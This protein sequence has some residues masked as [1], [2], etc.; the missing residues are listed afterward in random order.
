MMANQMNPKRHRSVNSKVASF[1]RFCNASG[2]SA[3]VIWFDYTGH[4]VLYTLLKPGQYIDMNTFVSHPWTFEKSSTGDRLNANFSQTFYPEDKKNCRQVVNITYPMYSLKE[5]S[6]QVIRD[7]IDVCNE[8]D[9]AQLELPKPLDGELQFLQ[10][11][12]NCA[13]VHSREPAG[14]E[15][16]GN[17]VVPHLCSFRNTL[18]SQF[19]QFGRY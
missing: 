10:T 15:N 5:R 3:S 16:A 19:S 2:S 7:C 18:L 12:K 13:Q 11:K 1:V 4:R 14:A 17:Q 6:L 8:N 9:L